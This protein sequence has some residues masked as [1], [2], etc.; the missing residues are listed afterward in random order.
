M[1]SRQ[2]RILD[3]VFTDP[4]PA[5]LDWADIESLFTALGGYLEEGRGSR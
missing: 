3:A 1:N 5:N 2:K 4:A